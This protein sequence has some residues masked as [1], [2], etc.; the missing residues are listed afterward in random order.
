MEQQEAFVDGDQQ[1][2]IL[3]VNYNTRDLTAACLNCIQQNF[4]LSEVQVCVV[5]NQSTDG[6]AEYLKTLDW[7]QLIERPVT[8]QETGKTAH[9][10]GLDAGIA[11]IHTPYLLCIHTDTFLF[12]AEVLDT[13]FAPM[14]A[15][16][17]VVC[18]GATQ[19]VHR[20]AI[21]MTWRRIKRAVRNHLRGLALNAGFDVKAPRKETRHVRSYCT[22][23]NLDVIKARNLSFHMNAD[24][25]AAAEP[26]PGYMMQDCLEAA[27]YRIARLPTRKIFRHIEHVHR[28][29]IVGTGGYRESHR[30]AR[31]YEMLLTPN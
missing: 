4:D 2:T 30:R 1:V 24:Q 21:R 29:T 7:I 5:D 27:G 13:L 19:Q 15:D 16:R 23:W 20:G 10:R 11:H 28:G 25:E 14:R 18:V 12:S 17:T 8:S 26:A 31:K 6:S 3:V 9:G 22:L